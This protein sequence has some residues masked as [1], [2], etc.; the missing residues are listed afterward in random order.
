MQN[1]LIKMEMLNKAL[2]ILPA[3]EEDIILT[4]IISK[5]AERFSELKN[6]EKNIVRNMNP[7][8]N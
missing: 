5:I 2:E 7:L 1:V 3:I 4:G 6:A 8:K